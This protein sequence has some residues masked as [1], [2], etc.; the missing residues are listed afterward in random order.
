VGGDV[1]H[2]VGTSYLVDGNWHEITLTYD[3]SSNGLV[4]LYVDGNLDTAQNNSGPWFWPTTQEIEL[5]RSHDA[6]WFI[7]DGQLDDFRMYNTILSPAE[8]TPISS[9]STSDQLEEP[10]ALEVRYN[11][12]TGTFGNSLTWPFGTLQSSPTL[13]QGAVWT[14]LTNATSPMPFLTTNP[15]TFYRLLGTP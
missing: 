13:G 15:A 1:N 8:V 6:Y 5:G 10:D 2:F 14:T 12:D 11:F 9:P 7:Y 4:S 3:Q